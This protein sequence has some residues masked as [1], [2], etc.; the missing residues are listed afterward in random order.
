MLVKMAGVTYMW[1]IKSKMAKLKN[2]TSVEDR[3]KAHEGYEL[4]IEAF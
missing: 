2:K 3:K 1:R 4:E